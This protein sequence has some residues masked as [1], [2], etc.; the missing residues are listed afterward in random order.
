MIQK[1][2][3]LR[4][5]QELAKVIARMLGKDPDE[6]IEIIDEVLIELLKIDTQN[7]KRLKPEEVI[8]FLTEE[9]GLEVLQMDFLAELF[10]K[11]GE[12]LYEAGQLV[13]SKDILRRLN[14]KSKT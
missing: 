4:W 14:V 9:K 12:L 2:F 6:S 7:L 8:P 5:A 1:D 11:R 3:I 13:E 10:A